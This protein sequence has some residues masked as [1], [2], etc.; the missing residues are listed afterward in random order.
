M[1]T[2]RSRH[3]ATTHFGARRGV[4]DGPDF[5]HEGYN[6]M[7]DKR[8]DGV[9]RLLHWTLMI[10][11]SFQLFGGLLVSTPGTLTYYYAHQRGGLLTTAPILVFWL[12]THANYDLPRL[13]PWNREG[14]KV[15]TA[16]LRGLLRGKLPRPGRT[17]GLSSFVHG[18]GLLAVTGMAATGT[19]IFLTIPG[20]RGA[21]A[22]S[23]SYTAFTELVLLHKIISYPVWIYWFGHVGFAVVHLLRR[24][25]GIGAIFRIRDRE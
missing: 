7:Q 11:V 15:V 4:V 20:G 1:R 8:W 3:R 2:R 19:L 22:D 10:M 6:T 9:I 25:T 13:F 5:P 16:E 18:L 24:S 23:T 21:W 17:R 14:M 12:W